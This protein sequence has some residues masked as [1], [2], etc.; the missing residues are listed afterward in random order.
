MATLW[1]GFLSPKPSRPKVALTQPTTAS[2]PVA[3]NELASTKAHLALQDQ[4]RAISPSPAPLRTA[5]KPNQNPVPPKQVV[6]RSRPTAPKVTPVATRIVQAPPRIITRT[7][8]VPAKVVAQAPARPAPAP[9]PAA[10]TNSSKPEDPFHKWATLA[11]LGQA[12]S[13]QNN[14]NSA[15]STNSS[16]V[17]SLNPMI[18]PVAAQGTDNTNYSAVDRQQNPMPGTTNNQDA[19]IPTVTIGQAQQATYNNPNP[20]TPQAYPETPQPSPEFPQTNP[21]T[22]QPNPESPPTNP[23]NP[24]YSSPRIALIA[25]NSNSQQQPLQPSNAETANT[26]TANTEIAGL[27]EGEAGIVNNAPTDY[28]SSPDQNYKEIPIGSSV[29][30]TVVVPMMWNDAGQNATR[31]RAA[32][33]LTEDLMATDGTVALPKGTMLVAQADSIA[34][35]NQLVSL[36]AI[37]IV[38]KDSAGNTQE[39]QIP[40]GIITIAGKDNSPLIAKGH[41]DRGASI[42]SQDALVAVLSG[43]GNVGKVINQPRSQTT[44]NSS[45]LGSNQTVT[46]TASNPSILAAAL[47]GVFGTAAQRIAQRSNQSQQE[48]MQKPNISVIPKGTEVA[49]F[50]NAF[51]KLNR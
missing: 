50:V 15:R 33:E 36:S 11:N 32:I 39:Q 41:F 24:Q 46:S 18:E 2:T 6:T 40:S 16:L 28:N 5:Q 22:P 25:N 44:I 9:A 12:A 38:Y 17:A 37:A 35:G 8:T 48:I 20:E 1:F 26:G 29:K 23:E 21:E 19:P 31:A 13:D 10:N 43:L 7:I 51:V 4:R 34:P 45:V 42:A 14:P 30:G 27:T 49:V 3:D 47:E